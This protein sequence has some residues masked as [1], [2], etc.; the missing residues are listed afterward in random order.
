MKRWHTEVPLM[1]TRVSTA[2]QTMIGRD[3]PELGR[4]RKHKPGD[5]GCPRCG[6]CHPSKRLPNADRQAARDRA[7]RF[8]LETAA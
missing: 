7:I 1:R 2:A 8:E 6:C 3:D 4:V 5:C